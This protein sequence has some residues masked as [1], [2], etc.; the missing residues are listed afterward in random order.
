MRGRVEQRYHLDAVVIRG[1]LRQMRVVECRLCRI[2]ILRDIVHIK[3][4]D[5]QCPRCRILC[6]AGYVLQAIDRDGLGQSQ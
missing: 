4:G 2:R 6:H 5:P 3:A 1:D